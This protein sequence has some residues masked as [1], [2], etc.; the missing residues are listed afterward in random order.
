VGSAALDGF[1]PGRS[2]VDPVAVPAGDVDLRRPV[3]EIAPVAS[4]VAP[5]PLGARAGAADFTLAVV[6]DASLR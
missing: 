6:E 4:H 1:R 3:T 2:D 5:R